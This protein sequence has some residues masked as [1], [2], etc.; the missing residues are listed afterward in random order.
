MKWKLLYLNEV[1]NDLSNLDN[2]VKSRVRKSIEK[3]AQNPLPK[4]EGGYGKPLG[5]VDGINLTGCSKIKLLGVGLR[6]V[7]KIQRTDNEM[8]V[9]IISARSDNEVYIEAEKRVKKYNL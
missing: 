7:Y 5:N 1:T 6:V 3:V 8:K 4:S 2:S 9:I